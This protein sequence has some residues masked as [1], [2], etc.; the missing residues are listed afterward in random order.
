MTNE[1]LINLLEK[2]NLKTK[3]L[4]DELGMTWQA[5]FTRM[6]GG[7]KTVYESAEHFY[8]S[9]IR[10]V[11]MDTNPTYGLSQWQYKADLKKWCNGLVISEIDA[12]NFESHLKYEL[13]EIHEYREDWTENNDPKFYPKNIIKPKKIIKFWEIKEQ[14][15]PRMPLG[16]TF[17]FLAESI[18]SY[19]YIENHYES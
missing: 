12:S 14:I 11:E 3:F 10:A 1:N 15:D 2:D 4:F 6:V 17:C 9:L 16:P 7:H 8:L 5:S 13:N 19:F 18:D